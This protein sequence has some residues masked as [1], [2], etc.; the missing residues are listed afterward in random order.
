[1]WTVEMRDDEGTLCGVS[2]V[3]IAVRA[4]APPG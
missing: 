4:M 3:I 2:R 1:V